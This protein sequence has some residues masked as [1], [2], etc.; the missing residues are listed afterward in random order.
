MAPFAERYP[1]WV[2]D[3]DA[4]RAHFQGR[5]P[6]SP[7]DVSW[8]SRLRPPSLPTPRLFI[9]HRQDAV[10]TTTALGISTV[11]VKS[12][13]S[14][15]IDVL[16][17]TLAQLNAQAATTGST[18]ALGIAAACVI[19]MALVN[20][21]HA[22]AVLSSNSRGS[23]WIPY[24]YGRVKKRA[25]TTTVASLVCPSAPPAD[26]PEYAQLGEIAHSLTDVGNW[27]ARELAVY[28]PGARLT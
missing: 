6:D 26:V 19:E 12:G 5:L 24:E 3:T 8:V 14:F 15:W 16:D 27:L 11:A 20:C 25:R 13:F 7:V 21:T 28:R 10:D 2:P 4:W 17:P 22:I 23:L 1:R 9:S 18:P